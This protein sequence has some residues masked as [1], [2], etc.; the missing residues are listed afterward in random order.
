MLTD[1]PGNQQRIMKKYTGGDSQT[2]IRTN[3][4][5]PSTGKFYIELWMVKDGGSYGSF[6]VAD[7]NH[8]FG[9]FFVGG[10]SSA[11]GVGWLDSLDR[12]YHDGSF[13]DDGNYNVHPYVSPDWS[14]GDVVMC[15]VNMDTGGVWF[16]L[17]GDWNYATPSAGGTADYT[18][19]EIVNST[20][21]YFMATHSILGSVLELRTNQGMSFYTPPSGFVMPDD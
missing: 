15:A 19:S 20:D 13:A 7:S 14:T 21:I 4:P 2:S 12:L 10:D 6:G 1:I 9:T 5:L 11:I 3:S 16:G 18:E 8:S 17:N